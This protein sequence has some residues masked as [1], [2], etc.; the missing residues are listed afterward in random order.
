MINISITIINQP[1]LNIVHLATNITK[2]LEAFKLPRRCV[3]LNT[4][5]AMSIN[6]IKSADTLPINN[7]SFI[8]LYDTHNNLQFIVDTTSP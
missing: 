4:K 3:N 8:L 2:L 6:T 5:S 1:M 7:K